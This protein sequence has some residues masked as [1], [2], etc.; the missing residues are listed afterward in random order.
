MRNTITRIMTWALIGGAWALAAT[1]SWAVQMVNLRAE[2][3]IKTVPLP[4]GGTTNIVMWGFALDAAV[5]TVPGPALIIAPGETQLVINVTNNLTVPVSVVIPGQDG[6]VLD[7]PHA[8]FTDTQGRTRARSFVKETPP[9]GINTYIWNDIRPGTY[10]YHSG[11]HPALQVQMGL[12]GMLKQDAVAGEVYAGVPYAIETNWIF[13]EIDFDVHDAVQ[14]GAYGTTVKSMIHS[15][16]EVYLLNGEPYR[17]G[18]LPLAAS[19]TNLVRLLNACYDERIPVL[20]GCYATLIA[21]DGRKYPYPKVENAITL[22][23]L[24]T[25]DALLISDQSEIVKFFDRRIL[26][27]FSSL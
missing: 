7:A 21:E 5:P 22:P 9:A 11:S 1:S 13:G 19:Q 24:K 27:V 17:V 4:G 6:F 3:F 10:L 15:V 25:R 14:A 26:A 12:Y 20:N 2:Q 18:E 16:P 8:T 23:A